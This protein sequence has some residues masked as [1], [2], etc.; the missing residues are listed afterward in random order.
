MNKI[1]ASRG[2]KKTKQNKKFSAAAED[3]CNK[4]D[5]LLAADDQFGNVS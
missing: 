4:T 2:I 1:M 3:G 5:Y